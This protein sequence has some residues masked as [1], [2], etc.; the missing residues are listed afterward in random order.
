M[1][2]KANPKVIGAFVVGAVALLLGG[3]VAFGGGQYFTPKGKAV[4]YFQN[5]S[6]SGL[7]VG[8]PVTFRGVKIGSVT[9]VV[10]HY[11]VD[12]QRLLIPV[13]IEIELN[14]FE[15]TS[16][17][18]N[19]KKNM[20]ALID[21]GL[22]GQ[23]VVQS[24]VT[25]QASVD[26]SFHPGTPVVLVGEE[27][28][29]VELPTIPSDI[30][31]M[32]A[33]VS[34]VLKQIAALPLDKIAA[35]TLDTVNT[36][37]VFVKNLDGHLDDVAATV[38]QV[39]DQADAALAEAKARLELKE[40]EPLTNL[41]DTITDARTLVNKVNTGLDPIIADATK[42]T[43]GTLATMDQM[44]LTLE[45]ARSSISPDSDLYFELT[46]TLKEIQN[47]ANSIRAFAD[48]VQRHPDALLM[49]KH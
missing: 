48:Y 23:L 9:D 46:R 45:T 21:R 47:T 38:K 22:R 33:N 7:D 17:E 39:G 18:E 20:P 6:M 12:N 24:L 15:I 36:T 2:A 8:S 25:G 11:D 30:D 44:R 1:A 49:G 42:L 27:K 37:N 19:S 3:V 26:L 32:K 31:T 14:H 4:L 13:Y 43:A 5:A 34:A 41:N 10:I 29:M 35:S 40:G 16:G 28:R